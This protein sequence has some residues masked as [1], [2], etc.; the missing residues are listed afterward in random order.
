[1]G[2]TCISV[3]ERLEFFEISI[4]YLNYYVFKHIGK[5]SVAGPLSNKGLIFEHITNLDG[6]RI[7]S[8]YPRLAE[9]KTDHN[10]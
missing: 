7:V 10:I 6:V 4:T 2:L 8:I 9:K 3:F 1:M 5:Q